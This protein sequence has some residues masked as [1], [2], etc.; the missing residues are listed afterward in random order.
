MAKA[1]TEL[2]GPCYGTRTSLQIDFFFFLFFPTLFLIRS[3]SKS[4][5]GLW[6]RKMGGFNGELK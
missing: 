3:E 1:L 2:G 6:G 4:E 5:W